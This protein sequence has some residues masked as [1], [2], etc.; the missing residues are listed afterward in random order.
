MIV[1]QKERF[2]EIAD[3]IRAKTGETGKIKPVDFAK[4][5]LQIHTGDWDSVQANGYRRDYSYAFANTAYKTLNPSYDIICERC[6]YMFMNAQELI[7]LANV[8]INVISSN[9]NMSYLC[10]GCINLINAP[11][12]AFDYSAATSVRTWVS[13]FA[14]CVSLE[15][16][17]IYLG[18]GQQNP[19]TV[20]NNMANCFFKC[21]N[22]KNLTFSGVG[23][24]INLDLSY[25]ADISVESL[26]SLS[27]CLMDV[28]QAEAGVYEIIINQNQQIK[29]NENKI[30]NVTL[31]D[32]ITQKG[33]SFIIK[34][35]EET[36][37]E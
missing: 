27:N 29:L 9:P 4:K 13:A 30:N 7:S 24:P 19:V 25:A 3:S 5:I 21:K 16:A 15:S 33:W 18:T 11:V 34:E 2:K 22:L 20:R 12:M 32:I 35:R 36:N 26:E 10:M 28:S 37:E 6:V 23:S 1:T 31:Y 17:D 8:N 14:N